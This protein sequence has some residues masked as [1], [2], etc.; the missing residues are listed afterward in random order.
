FWLIGTLG[1]PGTMQF[2]GKLNLLLALL[3]Y[4]YARVPEV[5]PTAIAAEARRRDRQ[6]QLF[7]WAAFV[8]GAAS[9]IYE[10][11]WT[12]MLALVLGASFQAFEL[13]L[14]AFI[15]GLALGGL[16]IR[17]RIDRF[18]DP[19]RVSGCVQL[20]MGLFALATVFVYH[21]SFDWMQW[22]LGVLSRNDSSYT[23]F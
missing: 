6:R 5:P 9:F 12:R 23:L 3:V 19:T 14:S 16:W 11:A 17:K 10:I 21:R 22:M 8:T 18:E 4:W 7:L 1:L 2:A 20:L 13:M 15:T